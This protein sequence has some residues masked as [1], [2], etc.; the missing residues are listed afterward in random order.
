[1]YGYSSEKYKIPESSLDDHSKGNSSLSLSSLK[2]AAFAECSRCKRNTHTSEKCHAKKDIFGK[3]LT[4][5]HRDLLDQ[6]QTRLT[7]KVKPVPQTKL[8]QTLMTKKEKECALW[9]EGKCVLGDTCFYSHSNPAGWD[10]RSRQLCIFH[11]SGSCMKSVL[12]PFSHEKSM[13]ACAFFHLKG[14]CS[15][16]E[17]CEFSHE[18][19]TEIQREELERDQAR[20]QS[21][22]KPSLSSHTHSNDLL[23]I[24]NNNK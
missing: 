21:K 16:R 14:G 6:R 9:V 1:M 22:S 2:N 11:R 10:P 7:K 17:D 5:F 23:S 15:K 19:L 24:Y 3:E 20:F 18:P 4:D 8:T 13:F 12:C